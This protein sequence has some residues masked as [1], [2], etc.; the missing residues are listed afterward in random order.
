MESS[1]VFFDFLGGGGTQLSPP[2]SEN[3]ENPMV[4]FDFLG[5]G[6]H[7]PPTHLTPK[8]LKIQMFSLILWVGGGAPGSPYEN[9]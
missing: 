6:R 5:G 2:H 3:Y 7:P 8:T 9:P 4:F 1:F